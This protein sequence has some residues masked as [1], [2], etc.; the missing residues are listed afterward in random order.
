MGNLRN[1]ID[2][3]LVNNEKDYLK[4]TSQLY[5]LA[6]IEMF[7]PDFSKIIMCEFRYGYIK[8]KYGNKLK[9]LL[10]DTDS[11]MREIKTED[12]YEDFNSDK[13]IFYFRNYPTKSKYHNDSNK[14]VTGKM[15]DKTAG[16]AITKFVV[17]RAKMY[18]Y[19]ADY[20]NE[21]KKAKG[22]NR[23]IVAPISQNEYK[24]VLLSNKCIRYTMNRIQ[25]K[26]HRIGM[27]EINQVFYQT[28]CFNFRY[29]QDSLFCQSII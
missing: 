28:Y 18:S 6:Y 4:C 27:Y 14:L 24:N 25:S 2:V 16:D 10:T 15:K 3:K 5:K 8:N 23:N 21:Y 1:R 26:D 19:F 9:L 20:N 17:L 12:V 13:E 7:I 22:V 11:L 29:N